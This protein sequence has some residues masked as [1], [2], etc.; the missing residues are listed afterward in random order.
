MYMGREG[1]KCVVGIVLYDLCL[2]TS[3]N[4]EGFEIYFF[5]RKTKHR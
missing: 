1:N 3:Q 2:D 5:L 4:H